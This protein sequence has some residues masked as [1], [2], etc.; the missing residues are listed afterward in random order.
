MRWHTRAVPLIGD[1][2]M[3]WRS[4][5]IRLREAGAPLAGSD[6]DILLDDRGGLG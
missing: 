2:A 5:M 4:E 3:S 1:H 6:L